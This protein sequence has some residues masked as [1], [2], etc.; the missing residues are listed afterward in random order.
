MKKNEAWFVVSTIS[1][2]LVKEKKQFQSAGSG[3]WISSKIIEITNVRSTSQLPS[4]QM[5]RIIN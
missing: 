2:G 3:C 4:D 1:I 5:G